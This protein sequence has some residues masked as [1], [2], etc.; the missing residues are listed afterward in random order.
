MGSLSHRILGPEKHS[1]PGNWDN[2]TSSS[3]QKGTTELKWLEKHAHHDILACNYHNTV[4]VMD[5]PGLWLAMKNFTNGRRPYR[6]VNKIPMNTRIN[7]K[8]SAH[9]LTHPQN[10]RTHVHI[11]GQCTTNYVWLALGSYKRKLISTIS[12]NSLFAKCIMHEINLLY[13]LTSKLLHEQ[14]LTISAHS[15]CIHLGNVSQW[16]TST[17]QSPNHLGHQSLQWW[18]PYPQLVLKEEYSVVQFRV[19]FAWWCKSL[20]DWSCRAAGSIDCSDGGKSQMR[21]HAIMK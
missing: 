2:N 9:V 10:A 21:L 6:L 20:E 8:S 17:S 19:K 4:W 5:V 13:G 14:I 3:P 15:H 12:Q 18:C 7:S 1:W 11:C 16:W